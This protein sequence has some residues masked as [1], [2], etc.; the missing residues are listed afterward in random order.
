MNALT[1][2]LGDSP[3]RVFL[4]LLVASFLVGLV[5][6]TLGWSPME[7]VRRL[8]DL[9]H[10]LWS[11]GIEAIYR[12]GDYIVLGG[13]IVVPIFIVMRLLSVRR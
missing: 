3:W 13:V 12:F 6:S 8:V 7:I 10:A 2:F 1:R 11:M 4:K 9:V 5:L